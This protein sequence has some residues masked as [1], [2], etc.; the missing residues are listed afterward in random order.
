MNS[1]HH[2]SDLDRLARKHASA[3]LGWYFH[4]CIYILVNLLLIGLSSL[5]GRHWAAFPALG[6]GLGLAIHGFVVL[7]TTSG[8]QLRERMVQ[9][10]RERLAQRDPW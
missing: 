4:A 8:Y 10:E 2:E 1:Q 5:S 7:L 9:R 6:W 3:K